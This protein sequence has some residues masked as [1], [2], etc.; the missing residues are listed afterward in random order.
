MSREEILST[1]N[2]I[3]V[4]G[5]ESTATSLTGILNHLSKNDGIMRRLSSDIRD[6]YKKEENITIDSI[7]D[8]PYLEAVLNEGLRMCNPVPGGLPRMV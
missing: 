8:L 2:F 5:S 7:Y 1:F 6:H 4:G 3:I